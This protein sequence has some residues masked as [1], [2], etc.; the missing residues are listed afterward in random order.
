MDIKIE[1][2]DMVLDR[3]GTAVYISGKEELIQRAMFCITSKKGGFVYNK[4]MGVEAVVS[5]ATER[6]IKE[7]EAKL[8][9]AVVNVQGV[10]VFLQSAE[11]MIDGTIKAEV[12]L[13]CGGE[14]FFREVIFD[15]EL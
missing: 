2:G 5:V 7:L 4:D 3:T 6:T 10:E 12:V 14:E 13:V 9:E 8:R 1:N 15:G 11:E